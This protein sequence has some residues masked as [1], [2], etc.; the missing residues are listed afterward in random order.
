MTSFECFLY[1]VHLSKYCSHTSTFIYL[2]LN[3]IVWLHIVNINKAKGEIWILAV[4][5]NSLNLILVDTMI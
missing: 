1:H 5:D 3:G 2:L 4:I